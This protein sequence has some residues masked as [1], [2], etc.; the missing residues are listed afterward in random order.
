MIPRAIRRLPSDRIPIYPRWTPRR[1]RGHPWRT[2]STAKSTSEH[3]APKTLGQKIGKGIGDLA[4]AVIFIFIL[5]Y[6]LDQAPSWDDWADGIS[7]VV[8]LMAVE[9]ERPEAQKQQQQQQPIIHRDELRVLVLEPGSGD[10]E[11]RCRRVNVRWSWRTRYDALSYTWGNE[12]GCETVVVDGQRVSVTQNLHSALRHLRYPRRRRV[13]WVD[14]LCINQDSTEERD[15]QVRRMGSIYEKARRVVIW[16]GEETKEVE[17]ALSLIADVASA[18]R[19]A[20][21]AQ[22]VSRRTRKDFAPVFALLRRPWFQRMWVIQEAVLGHEPILVCGRQ[23]IPWA[24]LQDICRSSA[25]QELVPLNENEVERGIHAVSMIEH[26]RHENHATYILGKRSKRVRHLGLLSALYETR[27]FKCKDDRDRIYSLL[28]IVT[29]VGPEDDE[30]QPNYKA[31]VTEVFEAVARWDV[32]KNQ[33][34][35]ILSYCSG[36][37]PGRP[38]L[39][40]WVPDFASLEGTSSIASLLGRKPP[41]GVNKGFGKYFYHRPTFSVDNDGRTVINLDAEV[42]DTVQHVGRVLEDLRIIAYSRPAVARGNW[43]VEID[44]AAAS[45]CRDWLQECVGIAYSSD[46]ARRSKPE[47][48]QLSVDWDLDSLGLSPGYYAKLQETLAPRLSRGPGL[49][50]SYARFLEG[51]SSTGTS[52]DTTVEEWHGRWVGDDATD[53]PQ[54]LDK[55]LRTFARCRRFC[56]T[57]AGELGWVPAGAAEGDL[58]CLVSGARVPI[59]LRKLPLE[60]KQ[61]RYQVIG[62]AYI[63]G[64]MDDG[65]AGVSKWTERE[66][67]ALV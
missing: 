25:F 16:L 45:S 50:G 46:P 27:D 32:E 38:D 35:E 15:A 34:L 23:T 6:A 11:V 55:S 9:D 24:T 40:S 62:D 51:V 47:E 26:G 31:S 7:R 29:N 4:G 52:D 21:G 57:R 5:K 33:S 17:G 22:A 28:S 66:R 18:Y 61:P 3:D 64:L 48:V 19:T 39:P 44:K 1:W 36:P 56:A 58:V 53:G 13:L 41:Q 12:T 14:A 30:V 65:K 20:S 10:D 49:V 67:F 59:I 42:V 8:P 2:Y 43:T 60:S 37:H 63:T 54:A